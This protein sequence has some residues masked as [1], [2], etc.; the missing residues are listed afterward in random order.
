MSLKTGGENFGRM[1]SL[2]GRLTAL[3]AGSAFALVLACTI[4]IQLNLVSSLEGEDDQFLVERTHVLRRLLAD[5]KVKSP[6]L[7]WEVESEWQGISAPQS[8][9]RIVDAS[10][11]TVTETPGMKDRLPSGLFPAA[12]RTCLEIT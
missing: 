4:I 5:G 11:K 7:R 8:F 9:V 1:W 12:L 2:A 10:G 6:E 3:Y